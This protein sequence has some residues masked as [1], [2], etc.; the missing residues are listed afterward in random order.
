MSK[1]VLLLA[2]ATCF[3]FSSY[4]QLNDNFKLG[5]EM[6]IL[7]LSNSE[8]LGLFLNIEPKLKVS[9]NA[10][11]GLRIAASINSDAIQNYDSLQYRIQA[12]GD[13]GILSLIPTYDYYWELNN[14][15]PYVGAGIGFYLF[16]TNMEVFKF[17]TKNPSED[18]QI[19]SIDN[20]IGILLRAGIEFRKTRIGLE[21]NYMP[22]ANIDI[23]SGETIGTVDNRYLG[24]SIGKVFGSG[25]RSS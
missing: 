6:G 7:D 9:K 15:R 10:F 8:K 23:N 24:I 16:G 14:Y 25:K 19:I 18:K 1:K 5:V 22:K 11:M 21:Y 13:N 2:I 17:P 12:E 3:L 20:K 4:A